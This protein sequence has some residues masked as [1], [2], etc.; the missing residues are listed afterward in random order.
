MT[1]SINA[2]AQKA[3]VQNST[4]EIVAPTQDGSV[5]TEYILDTKFTI[6][7]PKNDYS[8][9]EQTWSQVTSPET[10]KLFLKDGVETPERLPVEGMNQGGIGAVVKFGG[11]R[12]LVDQPVGT[13]GE[14]VVADTARIRYRVLAYKPEGQVFKKTTDIPDTQA[15][16]TYNPLGQL[17]VLKITGII[18]AG[19]NLLEKK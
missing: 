1:E 7:I 3:V 19:A 16:T 6:G 14:T 15:V 18:R 4:K 10:E 17:K 9:A 2:V 8:T 11:R 13:V 5:L 12:W